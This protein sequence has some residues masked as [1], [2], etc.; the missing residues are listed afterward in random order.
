MKIR[1]RLFARGFFRF[2]ANA[3]LSIKFN[4]VKCQCRVRVGIELLSFFAFVIGKED[5]PVLIE[6]LQ[7]NNPHRWPA[8]SPGRGQTH[9][10]DVPNTGFN[11]SSEPV[12]K[13]FDRIAIKIVAA[14]PA[15]D[16]FVAKTR[17]IER[18][19]FHIERAMIKIFARDKMSTL[20]W[21]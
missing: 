7:Q 12:S 2:P 18:R 5:E 10:V 3:N 8:I 19:L 15:T 17:V 13:L 16:V 9:C 14:Q 1:L 20:G 4:P 11:R 6:A 21:D